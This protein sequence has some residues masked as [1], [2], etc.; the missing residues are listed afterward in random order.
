MSPLFRDSHDLE[1][2]V[3]DY[4]DLMLYGA[5]LFRSGLQ[6]YLQDRP[7]EFQG[8]RSELGDVV[9]QLR[10]QRWAMTGRFCRPS[11]LFR[12]RR[13]LAALLESTH[14]ILDRLTATLQRCAVEQPELALAGNALLVEL[15]ES[16]NRAIDVLAQAARA[17]FAGA[18][19][20]AALAAQAMQARQAREETARLAE[21]YT[22]LIFRLDLRLSHKNQLGS[23]A[24][25]LACIADAACEAAEQLV[26]AHGGGPAPSTAWTLGRVATGWLALSIVAVAVTFAVVTLITP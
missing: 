23:V 12:N 1:G 17:H 10:D 21:Q 24:E 22:R 8:R 5:V 20:A 14:G 13:D 6:L 15:A 18:A 9:R 25:A 4:L 16:A 11:A 7:D 26:I 2:Q 19:R 3:N